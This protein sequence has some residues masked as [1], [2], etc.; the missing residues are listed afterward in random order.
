MK[1]SLLHVASSDIQNKNPKI[2]YE[3][4]KGQ[5]FHLQ[6]LCTHWAAT[7]VAAKAT[8]MSVLAMCSSFLEVDAAAVVAAMVAT[9]W[10]RHASI[11]V[12]SQSNY[13]NR[14]KGS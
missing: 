3:E 5:D 14:N 2:R 13:T 1:N 10:F 7:K 4:K 6:A 12:N 11:P 9:S 8:T